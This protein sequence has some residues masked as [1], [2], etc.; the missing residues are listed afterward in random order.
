[1]S[2]RYLRR[3]RSAIQQYLTLLDRLAEIGV[4]DGTGFDQIDGT[5]EE[6]FQVLLKSKITLGVLGRCK[7]AKLNE[8][9]EVA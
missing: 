9:I 5:P 2:K 1:M 7:G 8:K 6:T 3:S 4:A